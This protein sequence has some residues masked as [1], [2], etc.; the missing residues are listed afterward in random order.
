MGMGVMGDASMGTGLVVPVCSRAVPLAGS[1]DILASW[2]DPGDMG[3]WS[4][5]SLG[6]TAEA[7]GD[8]GRH[9]GEDIHDVEEEWVGKDHPSPLYVPPPLPDTWWMFVCAP[10]VCL[11]RLHQHHHIHTWERDVKSGSRVIPHDHL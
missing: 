8:E 10:P 9:Q 4:W 7:V 5:V 1:L 3:I 2:M 11:P 6:V